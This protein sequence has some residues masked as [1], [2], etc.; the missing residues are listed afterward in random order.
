VASN[1]QADAAGRVATAFT[2]P[3][4][5]RNGNR[6]V[7]MT[8]GLNSA[9]ANLQVND[10]LTIT[11]IE[12]IVVDRT[13]IQRQIVVQPTPPRI[14]RVPAERIVW[15]LQLRMGIE[16][17]QQD[18]AGEESLFDVRVQGGAFGQK[19][20][21]GVRE[22]DKKCSTLDIQIIDVSSRIKELDDII[23]INNAHLNLWFFT[24]LYG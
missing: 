20:E 10:P 16:D 4:E 18:A 14:I 24:F 22:I 17:L 15:R 6:I 12:R 19:L 11:R 13:I 8:D 2:I 3:E 21:V 7:E 9:Q 23:E 1:V 5:A